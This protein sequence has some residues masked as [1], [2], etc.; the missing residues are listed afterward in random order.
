MRRMATREEPTADAPSPP[1]PGA[2][3]LETLVEPV[4]RVARPS[5]APG[6]SRSRYAAGTTIG[7]YEIIRPL[8]QG[9]MGEVY[10]ARDVRLGRR[11]ALKFLLEVDPSY[12]VRFAVEAR[13]T[14]QR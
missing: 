12:S 10:L 8:G 13:D 2:S 9:G 3:E 11:V 1:R 14:A 7:H 5:A 6:P 4:A